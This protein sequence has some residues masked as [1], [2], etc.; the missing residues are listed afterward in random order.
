MYVTTVCVEIF[1]VEDYRGFY[2]H[3][4]GPRLFYTLYTVL[5]RLL[6]YGI[7]FNSV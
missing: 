1:A 4:R 3:G 5:A 7:F 6:D 2:F